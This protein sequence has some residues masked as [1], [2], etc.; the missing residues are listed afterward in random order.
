MTYAI[1]PVEYSPLNYLTGYRV[2][3]GEMDSFALSIECS[4]EEEKPYRA[5]IWQNALPQQAKCFHSWEDSLAYLRAFCDR[6]C[7]GFS[8]LL[9][10][11][12][13]DGETVWRMIS[14]SD[15]ANLRIRGAIIVRFEDLEEMNPFTVGR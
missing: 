2:V 5:S 4:E 14:A 12:N 11:R 15:I 9:G 8:G 1:W 10:V 6:N 13:D 7:P 3:A